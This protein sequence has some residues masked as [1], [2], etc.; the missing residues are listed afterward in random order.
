[1]NIDAF[2]EN[3]FGF[4]NPKVSFLARYNLN[5]LSLSAENL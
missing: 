4:M 1:M 2:S 3:L 5:S